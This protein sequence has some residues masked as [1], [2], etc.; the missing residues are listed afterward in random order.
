MLIQAIYFLLSINL[1][2][3]DSSLNIKTDK[4]NNIKDGLVL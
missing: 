1:A 2:F 3:T 4:N